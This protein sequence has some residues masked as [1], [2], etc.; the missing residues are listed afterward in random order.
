MHFLSL[1]YF[2]RLYSGSTSPRH[3]T[4]SGWQWGRR[5]PAVDILNEQSR[6]ANK[7]QSSSLG[8]GD[9]LTTSHCKMTACYEMLHRVSQF[10]GFCEHGNEP[11]GWRI[12]WLAW[13]LL[14]S[15]EGLSSVKLVAY[16]SRCTRGLTEHWN[17]CQHKGSIILCFLIL[18]NIQ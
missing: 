11:S 13:W 10:V 8:V 4:P 1:S 9:R 3:G 17:R 12:S 6:T 18:Y 5:P 15:Q 2:N 16:P 7:W 14:A